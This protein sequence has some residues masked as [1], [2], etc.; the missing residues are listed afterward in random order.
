[1]ARG[2]ATLH[3]LLSFVALASSKGAK[4]VVFCIF[5]RKE[6]DQF[7]ISKVIK[8]ILGLSFQIFTIALLDWDCDSNQV[9]STRLLW[10]LHSPTSTYFFFLC[11]FFLL[12]TSEL[13]LSL[14]W[15]LLCFFFSHSSSRFLVSTIY[16]QLNW[17]IVNMLLLLRF[18]LFIYVVKYFKLFC[19][20]GAGHTSKLWA[21]CSSSRLVASADLLSPFAFKTLVWHWLS[22]DQLVKP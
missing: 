18:W 22:K 4:D 19:L 11:F 21:P 5:L 10:W 1:M 3:R 8:I 20:F 13:F 15:L 17:N 7:R 2:E 12:Q 6:G 16:F 9:Y 14:F